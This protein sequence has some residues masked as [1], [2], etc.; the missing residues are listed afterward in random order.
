MITVRSIT[1]A[2]RHVKRGETVCA[3]GVGGAILVESRSLDWRCLYLRAGA[4]AN[5]R[6]A[7][8]RDDVHDWLREWFPRLKG[9]DPRGENRRG[10][11]QR[12]SAEER[13]RFYR[14]RAK[15]KFRKIK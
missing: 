8:T 6:Q 5:C 13:R 12:L 10:V 15:G 4:W 3:D 1:E 14:P 11:A 9:R 2:M 7:F